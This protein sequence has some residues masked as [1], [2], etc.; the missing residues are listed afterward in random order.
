MLSVWV[1]VVEP[2]F[3]SLGRER[4]G[5]GRDHGCSAVLRYHSRLHAADDRLSADRLLSSI[6]H[7]GELIHDLSF[8]RTRRT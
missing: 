7:L 3:G 1:Q 6:H 2:I 5:R 8:S 4:K